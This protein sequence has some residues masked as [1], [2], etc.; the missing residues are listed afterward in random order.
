MESLSPWRQ[1]C[2]HLLHFLGIVQQHALRQ[3]QLQLLGRQAI[4]VSKAVMR[5]TKPG[6][7]NSSAETLT[8]TTR[9]LQLIQCAAS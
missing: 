9:V 1:V 3:F 5:S 2:Q 6:C 7:R 8:D 4:T